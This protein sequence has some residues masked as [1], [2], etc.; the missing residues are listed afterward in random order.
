MAHGSC[1]LFATFDYIIGDKTLAALSVKTVWIFSS[2]ISQFFRDSLMNL[3]MLLLV[4]DSGKWVTY[5]ITFLISYS[6]ERKRAV[7]L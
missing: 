4:C 7:K 3:L 2:L 5:N 1:L 6:G